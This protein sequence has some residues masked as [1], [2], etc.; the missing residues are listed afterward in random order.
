MAGPDQTYSAFRRFLHDRTPRPVVSVNV[1]IYV[2]MLVS[3]GQYFAKLR[4]AAL[5]GPLVETGEWWRA[6]SSAFVHTGFWHLMLN[7][8]ALVFAGPG[9]RS[10]AL[11]CRLAS[12]C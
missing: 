6:L 9:H 2:A 4:G 8:L 3:N 7:M 10:S 12:P 5:Y 1:A 11:P